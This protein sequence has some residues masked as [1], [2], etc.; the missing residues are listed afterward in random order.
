MCNGP[1]LSES[2]ASTVYPC[3]GAT[4]ALHRHA[5]SR[6]AICATVQEDAEKMRKSSMQQYSDLKQRIFNFTGILVTTG[7]FVAAL[8][9][10]AEAAEAFA[11]GGTMAFVYQLALNSSVD[12]LALD[13]PPAVDLGLR[14][15]GKAP[16]QAPAVQQG[17]GGGGAGMQLAAGGMQRYA[18]VTATLL[19]AIIATQL[20]DGALCVLCAVLTCMCMGEALVLVSCAPVYATALCLL[21]AGAYFWSWCH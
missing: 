5:C 11:L 14:G 4:A 8:T 2:D 19:S 1:D 17:D 12:T 9:G 21:L 7:L 13:G 10:G 16:L 20:W 6:N 15:A 18:L 3:A